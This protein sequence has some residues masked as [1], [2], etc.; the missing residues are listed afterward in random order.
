M[1]IMYFLDPLKD[2]PALEDDEELKEHLID[3]GWEPPPEPDDDEYPRWPF[4]DNSLVIDSIDTGESPE[5]LYERLI[6]EGWQ[7]GDIMIAGRIVACRS[8]RRRRKKDLDDAIAEGLKRRNDQIAK[9][10]FET[11]LTIAGVVL[12]IL[13][14]LYR[15]FAGP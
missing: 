1:A 15:I 10:N 8:T 3:E 6:D 2:H 4:G 14:V 7:R 9:S 12:F 13:A 5:E 11:Y